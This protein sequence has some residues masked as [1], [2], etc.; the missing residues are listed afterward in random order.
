M[1]KVIIICPNILYFLTKITFTQIMRITDHVLQSRILT[2]SRKIMLILPRKIQLHKLCNMRNCFFLKIDGRMS[3]SLKKSFICVLSS[4][5][6][7]IWFHQPYIGF[8]QTG[9]LLFNQK[10]RMKLF[11]V[12]LQFGFSLNPYARSKLIKNYQALVRFGTKSIL[13]TLSYSLQS[14]WNSNFINKGL[15]SIGYIACHF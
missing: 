9:R 2:V 5:Y 10:V 6:R 14:R 15:K 8:L 1:P 11:I 7:A 13:S 3:D 4:Y 12:I